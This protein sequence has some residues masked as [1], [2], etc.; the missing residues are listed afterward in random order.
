VAAS[1]TFGRHMYALAGCKFLKY[2]SGC[3]S[4]RILWSHRHDTAGFAA[5]LHQVSRNHLGFGVI[6]VVLFFINES[7]S[8]FFLSS[9]RLAV[10]GIGGAH[11]LVT[12]SFQLG[13]RTSHNR[14]SPSKCGQASEFVECGLFVCGCGWTFV[15]FFFNWFGALTI[16]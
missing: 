16:N 11:C 12:G 7:T 1:L 6:S 9:E 15:K 5:M 13:A 14:E 8:S 2:Y 4:V 10:H 3:V